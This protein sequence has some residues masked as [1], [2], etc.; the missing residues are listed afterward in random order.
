MNIKRIK[1]LFNIY[2]EVIVDKTKP[3]WAQSPT[4]KRGY[5]RIATEEAFAT[6]ALIAESKRLIASGNAEPGFAKMGGFVFGNGLPPKVLDSKLLDLGDSR[7]HQMDADGIDYALLSLTSP[8]VQVF[9]ASKATGIA[10]EANDMLMEAVRKYPLRFGGLAAIAPQAPNEAAKEIARAKKMGL[11]GIIINSHTHGEYLDLPKFTPILEA[12]QDL[13]MP[14]YLHPREPAASWV[15]PYLDYGLYFATWGFAAE[16]ALHAMRLIMSGTLDRFPKLHIVLGHMGEG[17]PFWLARIDNRYKGQVVVGA[18]SVLELLPSEYFRR[19]FVITTSGVMDH[20]PLRLA[21]DV[22]GIERIQFAADY[23][24]ENAG[25][26]VRSLENSDLNE[27]ERMSIF[28][29]NASKY[30]G[31]NL[32]AISI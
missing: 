13:N 1:N 25:D 16:A 15:A 19:N 14:I 9:E 3:T 17:I 5:R 28:E 22:L 7:I 18:S 4:P 30:W 6:Q 21:I 11:K 26:G 20:A 23:P 8:G 29:T 12:A 24:Y 27:A 10:M 2:T 31:I 32:D